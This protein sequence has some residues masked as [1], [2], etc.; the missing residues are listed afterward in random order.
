VFHSC[1]TVRNTNLDFF[2]AIF[3]V[4]CQVWRLIV[5]RYD[6]ETH[7]NVNTC[8]PFH[9]RLGA[10]Y[11][12]TFGIAMV[13]LSLLLC[14]SSPRRPSRHPLLW[15]VLLRSS[16]VAQVLMCVLLVIGAIWADADSRWYSGVLA[17]EVTFLLYCL[18][19]ITMLLLSIHSTVGLT[20]SASDQRKL[21]SALISA[22]AVC[23]VRYVLLFAL[24]TTMLVYNVMS[25][26]TEQDGFASL[27]GALLPLSVIWSQL[28]PRSAIVKRSELQHRV[29][30]IMQY[31]RHHGLSLVLLGFFYSILAFIF[32]NAYQ[33]ACETSYMSFGSTAY[34]VTSAASKTLA[35]LV[36]LILL[37]VMFGTLTF[38]KAS[39]L[40]L[41][42]PFD[43]NVEF[44]VHVSI[45]CMALVVM[46]MVSGD[47]GIALFCFIPH[48]N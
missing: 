20:S 2:F 1:V 5:L 29:G 31:V 15:N 11:S 44:H 14:S 12:S 40:A 39:I 36:P 18:L 21:V 42:I 4:D 37:T 17:D 43:Y 30:P 46:H 23:L 28:W 16:Q 48:F 8:I 10:V 45:V 38:L 35:Q 24:A 3:S 47:N 25:L 7:L 41:T 32:L 6:T 19:S 22:T 27:V 13:T 34:Y 33:T 26:T 9:H